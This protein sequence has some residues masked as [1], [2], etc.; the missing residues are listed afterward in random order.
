MA[1][2][3]VEV[4][5]VSSKYYLVE[6]KTEQ[7]AR[8]LWSTGVENGE[9]VEREEVVAVLPYDDRFNDDEAADLLQDEEY[10]AD[11][12]VDSSN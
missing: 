7:T 11:D 2:F 9:F 10:E 5:T 1:L 6:A 12:Y 8:A 4:R 3:E